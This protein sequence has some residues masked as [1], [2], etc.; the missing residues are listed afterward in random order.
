MHASPSTV[1]FRIILV[2][3][4]LVAIDFYAFRSIKTSYSDIQSERTKQVINWVYWGV[5]VFFMLLT[6]YGLFIFNRFT[7]PRGG[8]FV[9]IMTIFFLLYIPKL[10][11]ITFLLIEDIGRLL[12]A[13]G[14]GVGKMVSDSFADTPYF[15]G[16]RTFLSQLA[17]AL[18]SIP[19]FSILYGITKGKYNYKVHHVSL[20]FKD[21]PEAF[22]GLTITQIS[23]IHSG[24][25][26]DEAAVKHGIDLINKQKS[27]LLFFTGDLVNNLA[28]EMEPWI[29]LFKQLN[30]PMGMFSIFGNHDYG[31]YVSWESEEMKQ[32]NFNQI[33]EIHKELGFKLMLNKS[34]DIEKDGQKISLMGIENWG[35]GGFA[36]YGD[37]EKAL[38]NVANDSFKILLS[39]DPS[40]WTA[41][42]LDHS[43]HIH[44]TLS[45]HTHGMQFGVEIP[46]IKW[47]PVQYRYPNWAGL[48]EEKNK[49]LYVNRGFGFIGFPGRVG[50]W[51]EIT[52]ITLQKA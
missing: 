20:K 22:N 11:L 45:G 46:G 43:K 12:R 19:F 48:Y 36:K 28:S 14:V 35:S 26:D 18:A 5:N 41:Q 29:P 6:T 3:L 40:H 49:Y 16:R 33:K 9:L 15:E 27:D 37:L 32:K 44:L 23:D 2:M 1:I 17:L 47:S 7:G 39:H 24:S 30:A 13:G 4:I 25:F 10:I 52:V 38:S 50:I 51:P 31:D 8:V 34:F 21:L 42:T